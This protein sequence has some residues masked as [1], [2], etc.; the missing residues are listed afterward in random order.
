MSDK[1]EKII[2]WNK[3]FSG[4]RSNMFDVYLKKLKFYL[5]SLCM[6]KHFLSD[7][8]GNCLI[9]IKK[10]FNDLKCLEGLVLIPE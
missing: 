8:A 9:S 1:N 2:L 3:D 4:L 5:F 7:H 10:N 6:L